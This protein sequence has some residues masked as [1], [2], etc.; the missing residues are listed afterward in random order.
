MRIRFRAAGIA[1]GVLMALMVQSAKADTYH[2]TGQ[3]DR[4]YCDSWFGFSCPNMPDISYSLDFS[5]EPPVLDKS[6]L[7]G[8]VYLFIDAI[9]GEINGVPVSCIKTGSTACWDLLAAHGNYAGPP[10]PDGYVGFPVTS[11]G[12]PWYV[13]GGTDAGP[14]D[15][16]SAPHVGVLIGDEHVWAT[17]NIVNTPE[18]STL[19]FLGIGVLGL[20]G[21]TLLKNRLS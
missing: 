10:I 8:N 15:I 17:W 9:S 1:I 2:A 4:S 6:N 16:T 19:L 3:T 11:S 14:F 21:L 5:T 13:S 18:P 20:M 12:I 7:R